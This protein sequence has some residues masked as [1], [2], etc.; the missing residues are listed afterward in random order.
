[1][2]FIT[3]SQQCTITDN[4]SPQAWERK[5]EYAC[6][7]NFFKHA[8]YQHIYTC[9]FVI[10]H[11]KMCCIP[12]A[13]NFWFCTACMLSHIHTIHD[14]FSW[15][16]QPVDLS[17]VIV[18]TKNMHNLVSWYTR[19]GVTYTLML[20]NHSKRHKKIRLCPR[21]IV[22]MRWTTHILSTTK[23][24]FPQLQRQE[25]V[26]RDSMIDS[27]STI[28]VIDDDQKLRLTPEK[29]PLVRKVP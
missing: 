20:K 29:N 13:H 6:S 7:R 16:V 8:C 11:L 18:S 22:H 19:R 25:H 9:S 27:H 1:M 14:S 23:S 3:H 26:L 4:I 5:I 12:P 17:Q 2:T 24:D 21:V 10:S 28:V 15:P